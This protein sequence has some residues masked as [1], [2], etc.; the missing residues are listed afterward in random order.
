MMSLHL[1]AN[2]NNRYELRM[3]SRPEYH[4][5]QTVDIAKCRINTSPFNFKSILVASQ[6]SIRHLP[7]IPSEHPII[8]QKHPFT[9]TFI[10]SNY[11]PN[12][13][14][15]SGWLKKIGRIMKATKRR[16]CSLRDSMLYIYNKDTDTAPSRVIFVQ[17]CYVDTYVSWCCLH[18]NKFQFYSTLGNY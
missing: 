5:Q 10:F 9:P 8:P 3:L 17:G 13:V 4:L 1:Q 14:G 6:Y 2:T 7:Q 11:I 12:S 16:W 18:S 15:M